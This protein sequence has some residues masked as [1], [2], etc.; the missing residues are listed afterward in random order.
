MGPKANRKGENQ[1]ENQGDVKRKGPRRKVTPLKGTIAWVAMMVRRWEQRKAH[2]TAMAKE[3]KMSVTAYIKAKGL[4]PLGDKPKW[5]AKDDPDTNH[6]GTR[7]WCRMMWQEYNMSKL[8]SLLECT[9]QFLMF[10]PLNSNSI[11]TLHAAT[12]M[13]SRNE[14]YFGRV[15]AAKDECGGVLQEDED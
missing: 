11:L 8:V 9:I 4:E 6:P 15:E 7:G 14:P 3:H 13:F 12:C 10:N 5:I 2:L 1:G